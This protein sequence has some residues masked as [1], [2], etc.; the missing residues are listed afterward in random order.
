ML[1][2]VN[3]YH[4]HPPNPYP[5]RLPKE[6]PLSFERL[7]AHLGNG[8]FPLGYGAFT[9]GERIEGMTDYCHCLPSGTGRRYSSRNMPGF[10][11]SLAF[12]FSSMCHSFPRFFVTLGT[13]PRTHRRACSAPFNWPFLDRLRSTGCSEAGVGQGMAL[14][15]WCGLVSAP[16]QTVCA[17]R[18]WPESLWAQRPRTGWSN[19][20]RRTHDPAGPTG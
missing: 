12:P 7:V 17:D 14:S 13:I 15:R 6:F 20:R 18:A 5:Y 4:S 2:G 19:L 3:G 9:R 11:E 1:P 16:G 8:R 10:F